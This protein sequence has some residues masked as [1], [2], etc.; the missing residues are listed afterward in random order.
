[1]TMGEARSTIAPDAPVSVVVCNYNGERYLPACLD[2]LFGLEG[3]IDECLVVDNRSTT[4]VN[5]NATFRYFPQQFFSHNSS[6]LRRQGSQLDNHIILGK[7][8]I[9]ILRPRDVT[10][11]QKRIRNARRIGHDGHTKWH[12]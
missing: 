3:G 11:L 2:A 10:I 6:V 9:E 1:M 12:Q 5:E 4:N 7:E 8:F